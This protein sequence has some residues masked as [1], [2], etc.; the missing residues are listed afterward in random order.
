MSRDWIFAIFS[1]WFNTENL[2]KR[3]E[4]FMIQIFDGMFNSYFKII[5]V[6]IQ[7]SYAH[8][9]IPGAPSL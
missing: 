6:N 7:Y 2:Q 8:I 9:F 5:Q 1:Y 4:I 3:N